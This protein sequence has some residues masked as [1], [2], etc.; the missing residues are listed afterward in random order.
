MI[1]TMFFGMVPLINEHLQMLFGFIVKY[2]ESLNVTG[3]TLSD[4]S[5]GDISDLFFT[6]EPIP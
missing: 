3:I 4:V 5:S 6:M 1:S 2:C